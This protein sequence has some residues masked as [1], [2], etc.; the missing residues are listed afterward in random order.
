[1]VSGRNVIVNW[2]TATEVNSFKF[3]VERGVT[4]AGT[5]NSV[6]EVLASK[7]SNSPKSYS[8]TDKNL[9]TGK[10]SYR[11]K[12]IDND[13]SIE[14]SSIM[15][16]AE[17]TLPNEFSV[18]QN[19]PNPFNPGTQISF[20]LPNDAQVVIELYAITGTKIAMVT[21][22]HMNAG[23]NSFYLNMG[24]YNLPSGAYFYKVIAS[25]SA[26][27]KTYSQTKKMVYMK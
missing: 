16:T 5:W 6:G 1:V 20:E 15:A 14:Y 9:N 27:G 25:E 4:G 8:Y 22:N 11:L 19:Y 7:Y 23:Y 21:N 2:T 17:V 13:G 3:V 24:K 12:M 18:A 10:Y 26:T